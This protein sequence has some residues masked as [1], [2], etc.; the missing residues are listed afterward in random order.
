MGLGR[1]DGRQEELDVLEQLHKDPAQATGDHWSKLLVVLHTH[2]HF[3]AG[4]HH[5]LNQD[6]TILRPWRGSASTRQHPLVAF[7]DG[8]E[9]CN[10]QKHGARLGLVEQFGRFDLE[11][12]READ[13]ARR[14]HRTVGAVH[15]A[16]PRGPNAVQGQDG[17]TLALR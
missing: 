4:L 13:L 1:L 9:V 12:H 14:G 11:H 2:D 16:L 5:L 15:Q 6:A 10:P 17:L 3:E 7:G 8:V